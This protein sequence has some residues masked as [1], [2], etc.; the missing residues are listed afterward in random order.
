[1]EGD[2]VDDFGTKINNPLQRFK[3][4][5]E[6]CSIAMLLLDVMGF[7]FETHMIIDTY[8]KDITLLLNKTAVRLRTNVHYLI[9]Y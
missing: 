8:Y 5:E 2:F 9:A 1:M 3:N 4:V 6:L 7:I